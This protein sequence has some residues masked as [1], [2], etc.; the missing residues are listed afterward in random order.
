M[1]LMASNLSPELEQLRAEIAAAAARMIAEDGADYGTAKRKA[2]ELCVGGKRGGGGKTRGDFLPDNAQIEE[3]VRIYNELFF[4]GTQPARL[5]HLR[6]IAAE[7]MAELVQFHPY[8]TGAVLNGTAGEHSDI[9]LHLFVDSPKD[10]EIF[11][12]NKNV[13]FEVSSSPPLKT[14]GNNDPVETLSFMYKKEGL[15]LT[16]YETDDLRGS[17]RAASGGR[18]LRA[19]LN[20]V[21]AL[22]DK[23]ED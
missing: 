19:D 6:K 20:T 8:L 23:E 4:A 18:I 3:E 9:Y 15:H 16:L 1:P 12:F 2:V 11:L 5:L 10:V 14:G 7:I 17:I 21:L 13:Q 22:I